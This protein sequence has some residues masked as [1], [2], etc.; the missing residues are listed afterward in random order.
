M[1][2]RIL[3]VLFALSALPLLGAPTIRNGSGATTPS[4]GTDY[5]RAP[6][7]TSGYISPSPLQPAPITNPTIRNSGATTSGYI[8]PSPLGRPNTSA[9]QPI[10]QSPTGIGR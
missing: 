10:V 3:I 5:Q 9:K 1:K 2:Q 7:S 6:R 8:S 4:G